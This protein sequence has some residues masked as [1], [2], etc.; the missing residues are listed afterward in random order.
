[1]DNN[2][3]EPDQQEQRHWSPRYRL[4][5]ITVYLLIIVALAALSLQSV[6]S[7]NG[8]D[9]AGSALRWLPIGLVLVLSSVGINLLPTVVAKVWREPNKANIG[10]V[11]LAGWLWRTL[12]LPLRAFW[13]LLAVA[14]LVGGGLVI[15]PEPTG[16]EPGKLRIMTAFVPSP[17][18]PRSLLV[19]QWNRLHPQNPAMFDYV[20]GET[21]QQHERMV[22]DA[23]AGGPHSADVYVLDLVWMAEF[24]EE[25]YVRE[26]AHPRLSETQL[27]DFLPNV[28]ATCKWEGKL[29]A[30]PFN[31]DA[32]L[33]FYRS[34]LKDVTA[35]ESW[36]AYFG[37]AALAQMPPAKTAF[38]SIVAANAAQLADE[39]MLTITAFEAIWAAGG[40]VVGPNG[41]LLLTP[42]GSINFTPVDLKGIANLAAAAKNPGLVTADAG[43]MTADL[44]V[45]AFA[46][47][48]TLFMRNW[49]VA[50]NDVGDRVPFKIVAPTTASVLGGQNL[51]ISATSG[52][53]RAA[54]AL[55]EFL[56][57]ASSQLI[58]SELG[59]F[60]PTRQSAYTI[61]KR[62][63]S[64]EIRAAVERARPR[65]ITR[66]YTEFS[67]TFR[68]G[69]GRALNADGQLEPD[70]AKQ[71]AD[72]W[73]CAGTG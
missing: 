5:V 25:G 69:I 6:A 46:S 61:A 68:R 66:C 36:D 32:G 11:D 59:G 56:T 67:R 19:E 30:L 53:P 52:K 34:D 3:E 60:A 43:Q 31:T 26:L 10:F 41:Q 15:R 4:V 71:A 35:P 2:P 23:K 70:F 37:S 12:R 54:Q 18:D 51:A 33:L 29:W 44:A 39:E 20:A 42:D 17:N 28:I 48:R 45:D 72:A 50:Q 63:F 14:V 27:S 24:V 49:P 16:L 73:R 38:P 7:V 57:S 8:P 40:E 55:I 1:M 21:D 47:G 58:L 62:A 65:P 13:V 22:N 64:P 9:G